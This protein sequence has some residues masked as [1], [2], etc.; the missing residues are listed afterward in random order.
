[1]NG[2]IKY[3]QTS[4]SDCVCNLCQK[5]VD[6][7]SEDHIP[8]KGWMKPRPLVVE[9]YPEG[10]K[11]DIYRPTTKNNGLVFRT[12]C[13]SCNNFLGARYDKA[14]KEFVYEITRFSESPLNVFRSFPVSAQPTLITK[15]VL[16]HM[17][18]S[19]TDFCNSNIDKE[20]RRYV[21]SD[22]EKLSPKIKLYYWYYPYDNAIVSNDINACDLSNGTS[23][24]YSVLKAYPV[25]FMLMYDSEM[26]DKRFYELTKYIRKEE[27][28]RVRVPFR[29]DFYPY[30]F[31]ES[32]EFT[33]CRL[34]PKQRTNLIA[35]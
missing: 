7:L 17:L 30:N 18:A 22:C 35:H 25:A 24:F 28:A 8:P 32:N 27:T 12:L 29:L 16:G 31:P 11:D 23:A 34:V 13:S 10:S 2:S 20:I 9:P 1:M 15:A 21:M 26:S 6:K 33:K 14:L 19:K 5:K 4:R 3:P